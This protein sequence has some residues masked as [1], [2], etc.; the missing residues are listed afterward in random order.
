MS[1][2]QIDRINQI[3]DKAIDR[4]IPVLLILAAICAVE[5]LVVNLWRWGMQG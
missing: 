4:A 1:D 2:T 3:I 5:L